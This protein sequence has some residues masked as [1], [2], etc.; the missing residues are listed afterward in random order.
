MNHYDRY[1]AEIR[2]KYNIEALEVD[3]VPQAVNETTVSDFVNKKENEAAK[4]NKLKL[5]VGTTEF[6]GELI[7]MYY[8][9]SR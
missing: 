2:R 3:G 5:A 9:V 4:L 6:N 1:M 7:R 8:E